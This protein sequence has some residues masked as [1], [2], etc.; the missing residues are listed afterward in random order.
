M[1]ASAVWRGCRQRADE[2]GRVRV[3]G[4]ALDVHAQLLGAVDDRLRALV[5]A[6]DL[7]PH[8]R[9]LLGPEDLRRV[10][11]ERTGH[12]DAVAE[13]RVAVLVRRVGSADRDAVDHRL[14]AVDRRDE[15]LVADRDRAG[16]DGVDVLVVDH[17]LTAGLTLLLGR[18]D[19]ARGELDGVTVDATELLVEV[20]HGQLG[21]LGRARA[22]VGRTALLVHPTDRERRLAR[23]S[24]TLGLRADVLGVVGDAGADRL[25]AGLRRVL[26]RGGVARRATRRAV[27]AAVVVATTD[28]H[29]EHQHCGTQGQQ[30][31]QLERPGR[32]AHHVVLHR[33]PPP[34]TT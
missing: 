1:I 28:G 19:V 22:D 16:P 15:R 17:L 9:D 25:V 34:R 5:D 4:D 31:A 30:R 3:P 7:R 27:A 26:R 11:G 13:E 24:C 8:D 33:Q 14:L 10:R 12:A 18:R 23:I 21:P 2:V 20:L 32:L 29:D 6:G